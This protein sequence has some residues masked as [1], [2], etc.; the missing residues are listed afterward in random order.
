VYVT[1]ELSHHAVLARLAAGSSVILAEHSSS[2]RGYLPK[3]AQKLAELAD[4]A[5][6]VLVSERDREPLENW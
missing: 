6:E 4:G 2:E 3:Y 1:G 5:L